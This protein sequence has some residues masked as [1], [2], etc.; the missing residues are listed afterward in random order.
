MLRGEAKSALHRLK[1]F[2]PE[3]DHLRRA[4]PAP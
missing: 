2:R 3:G 1:P 4:G